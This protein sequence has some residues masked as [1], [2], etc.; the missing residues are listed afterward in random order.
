MISTGL[1]KKF[2]ARP[3]EA[4]QQETK[5]TYDP[6][7]EGSYTVK[8]LEVAPWEKQVKDVYINTRDD[9]N[10]PVK[11]STGKTVKE[12][13]KN[14]EYYNAS[15]T[16]EIAGGEYQGRRLWSNLTTHPNASFITDNFLFA[17][18]AKEMVASEIPTKT[19]GKTLDVTV[20]IVSY[21]RK[22]V[23]P[24]TGLPRVEKKTK[25]EVK[26]FKKASLIQTTDTEDL[27]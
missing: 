21:E 7:P 17:I 5:R 8:V 25:N 20:D 6:I 19:V 16:F 9:K 3:D 2:V 10:R 27:F 4:P 24:E 14:V 15:I 11:D 1:D 22:V 26:Q 13:V 18:G 12:L 23:D